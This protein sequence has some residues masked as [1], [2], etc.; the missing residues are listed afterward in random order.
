[1]STPTTDACFLYDG[2]VC[3][4]EAKSPAARDWLEDRLPGQWRAG[5]LWCVEDAA[6]LPLRDEMVAAGFAVE[7]HQLGPTY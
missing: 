4:I 3:L 7:G 1:M 2:T 6:V 5:V